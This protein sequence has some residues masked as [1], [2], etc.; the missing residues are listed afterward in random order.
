MWMDRC[1]VLNQ[2]AV[3]DTQ[4]GVPAYPFVQRGTVVPE[5]NVTGLAVGNHFYLN[6]ATSKMYFFNGTVGTEVGWN[7]LN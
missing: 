5:N 1:G 7:I 4:N 6:T 2:Q 3:C